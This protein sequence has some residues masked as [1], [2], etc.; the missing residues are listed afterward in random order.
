MKMNHLDDEPEPIIELC[1]ETGCRANL[2]KDIAGFLRRNNGTTPISE[3]EKTFEA[4]G[5]AL[6][7]TLENMV[8]NNTI[9]VKISPYEQL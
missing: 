6:F 4:Q 1:D 2:E 3:L 7:E 8:I 5:D 9:K